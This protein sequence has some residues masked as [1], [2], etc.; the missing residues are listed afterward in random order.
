V[1]STASAEILTGYFGNNFGFIDSSEVYFGLP[2]REFSSFYQAAD[3]AAISRL[4]GGI[5]FRDAIENGVTQGRK[6]G[7]SIRNRIEKL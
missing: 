3:E 1:I 6:I 7:K 2:V 5:H 4:Y